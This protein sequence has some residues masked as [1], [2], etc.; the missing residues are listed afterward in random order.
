M[1]IQYK[2]SSRNSPNK[3]DIILGYNIFSVPLLIHCFRV[4]KRAKEKTAD[5]I[6][7]EIFGK[8]GHLANRLCCLQS[9]AT[10]YYHKYQNWLFLS[11][12]LKKGTDHS[13]M[14]QLFFPACSVH[15]GWSLLFHLSQIW[16][17]ELSNKKNLVRSG[18]IPREFCSCRHRHLTP[19]GISHER[20]YQWVSAGDSTLPC[21]VMR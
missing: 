19:S 5:E 7:D 14:E 4:C 13:G 17:T 1:N 2:H 18:I 12:V 9:R 3:S 20:K 11:P 6:W 15:F 10:K 8:S 16:I 21:C